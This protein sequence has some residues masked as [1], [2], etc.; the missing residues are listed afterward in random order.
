MTNIHEKERLRR[1]ARAR[2]VGAAAI[3]DE[4][5]EAR[6]REGSLFAEAQRHALLAAYALERL[7]R[8]GHSDEAAA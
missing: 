1:M 3:L 8:E 6:A 5:I 7:A 4:V 2:L